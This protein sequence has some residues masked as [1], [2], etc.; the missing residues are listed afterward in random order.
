MK[1]CNTCEACDE[2]HDIENNFC[3]GFIF[4]KIFVFTGCSVLQA[5]LKKYPSTQVFC[6]KWQNNRLVITLKRLLAVWW[7]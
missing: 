7:K 2:W 5:L 3:I 6:F 4:A 1:H